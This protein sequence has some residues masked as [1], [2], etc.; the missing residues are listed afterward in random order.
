MK[1]GR[2]RR[3]PNQALRLLLA[4]AGWSGAQLAREVNALGAVQ[5]TALHY[6]RTAVAHWLAGSRPRRPVPAL[7][8]EALSRRLGRPVRE[9]DTGLGPAVGAA[10]GPGAPAGEPSA[11]ERLD[12]VLRT[13]GRRRVALAGAYSLA[14]LAIPYGPSAI[15]HGPLTV[16]HGPAAIHRGPPEPGRRSPLPPGRVG[17]A[18]VAAAHELLALF[19]RGDAVLGAGPVYEPLRQYLSASVLPWLQR[20]MKPAVRRELLTVASRLTYLCAFTHFDMNRH[21]AAQRLYLTSV[22]LAREAGDRV[23]CGLALRGLSVQAHA[24]GHFAE[25]HHLAERAAETAL[26]Q[27]PPHQ[28]AF[29][30]GQLAVALAGRGDPRHAR[31]LAA[32]ERCLE[33]SQN[34]DTP[35]GAF[36]PGSLALQRAAVATSRGDRHAAARALDLSLRH[37][38]ADERRSRALS[39]AELAETQ[40][41]IGHLEQACRTWHEFLDLYPRVDSARADDRVRLLT[42]KARPH[43]ANPVVTALLGRVR[44]MHRRRPASHGPA[45]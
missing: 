4:E 35:V 33:R 8:A 26:H 45:T 40:L 6:D 37:R 44:E 23:G 41:A 2:T 12:E 22:E 29:F 27:V 10:H 28:Q 16:P 34:G 17:M 18:H 39:L 43:S 42:A 32:A 21:A 25:A 5:G 3:T 20:D 14:A 7:V 30:H 24:L 13:T 38:P 31:H 11:V 1:S 9:Q 36:H 19:S 15:P